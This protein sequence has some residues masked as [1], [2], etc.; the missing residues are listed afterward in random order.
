MKYSAALSLAVAP[1]AM[2][3]AIRNV[4]PVE[5]RNNH[6]QRLGGGN[7][8][9]VEASNTQII[10]IWANPGNNAAT[11]TIQQAVTVTQTVTAGAAAT[12][13]GTATISAGATTTVAGT[14]ATHTV[15]VGGSAGLA[16]SPSEIQANVGDMVIFT[17]MSQN[18]T[19]TQ[20]SFATPCDPL[21]GGMDSNFQPNKDN[22]VV[23]APQVAMQVMTTDPIWFYC[24][25][26]GHCGKGMV[27]SINPTAEKTQAIFQAMA[28]AQKGQ[29][30]GSAI[31]GNAT[32]SAV[33]SDSAAATSIASATSVAGATETASAGGAI[34]TGTG[35]LVAGACVCAV[36][37]GAGSFPAVNAQGI[38]NFGGV[39][40]AIPA[41][42]AEVF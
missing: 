8:V 2:A 12:T 6:L 34:Q 38:G 7:G 23:P 22:S 24:K 9:A 18:H 1:L 39:P 28:I 41:S 3:K 11:T 16:Y 5:A 4:Y 31:T 32:T 29:G 30:A 20:S 21:A 33:A 36:T 26:T 17:F 35:Q 19:V 37:C 42:M 25:Q 27:F 15:Q 40:G 10:I 13:V 14:G